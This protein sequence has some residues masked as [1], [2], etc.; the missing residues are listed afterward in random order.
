MSDVETQG[1]ELANN[2]RSRM[3]NRN[4]WRRNNNSIKTD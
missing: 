1:Y 4:T 3:R 2:M